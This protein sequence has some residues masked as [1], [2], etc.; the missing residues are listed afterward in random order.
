MMRILCRH[1]LAY[2][3]WCYTVFAHAEGPIPISAQALSTLVTV[4]QASAPAQV[5]PLNRP[6]LSAEVSGQITQ[7]PVRVG[8]VVQ[9]GD[10]LVAL[11]CTAHQARKQAATAAL[12]RAQAQRTFAKQQL[13]RAQNL[14]RKGSV[15]KELLEQRRLALNTAQADVQAQQAQQ[16]LAALEVQHCRITAP[17]TALLSQRLGNLGDFAT[18]GT[19]LLELVQLDQLEVS[20]DLRADQAASLADAQN[21]RFRYQDQ[22]YALQVR[23]ILPVVDARTR[24]RIARLTFQADSATIGAAG[25]LLWQ[26]AQ[27]LLPADYLVRRANQLGVFIVQQQQA[28]FVPLPQAREGQPTPVDLATDTVLVVEG[29]QRLQDG[30]SVQVR[31]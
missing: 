9:A 14:K 27:P 7:L 20:A 4:Q 21:I 13:R 17:F 23:A 8:E 1:W 16:G 2:A 25:R 18:P 3:L 24:T 12:K 30:D 5:T 10:L 29:R 15:S 11:D 28:V 6:R 19:P 22:E 31:P 26:S